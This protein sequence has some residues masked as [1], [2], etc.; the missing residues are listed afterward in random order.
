MKRMLALVLTILFTTSGLI[1]FAERINDP[2]VANDFRKTT[3]INTTLNFR[4]A[5]FKNSVNPPSGGTL[6]SITVT[7]LV[8]EASGTLR[9]GTAAVKK[10][11]E[12]KTGDLDR[13]N[14]VP[15]KDYKG[16]AIFTW[17]AQYG[18]ASSPYPSAVV[19]TVGDGTARASEPP[20][21]EPSETPSAS[22]VPTEAPTE[23]P[24]APGTPTESPTEAP[25]A[26]PEPTKTPAP[27]QKP[28]QY[29]DML[30]HW[31]AYSAGMLGAEGII[32]GEE[33][34]GRFYFYPD[35]ILTRMD[36]ITLACSVFGVKTKDSL[37]DN[38]FADMNVPD[39]MLRQAIAAYENGI[40]SGTPKNGK[41]YLNPYDTLT[42]AEAVKILD[43]G[44]KLV[45]PA[46]EALSFADSDEIPAWATDAVKNMEAYGIIRGYEDNTFRPFEHINKAQA[47][48]MLYQAFKYR[49]KV[50]KTQSVFNQIFYGEI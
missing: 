46:R 31:A 15:A 35:K 22:S 16:E 14:Y 10:N 2:L 13:L 18:T 40:I 9:L 42:R 37:A 24:S 8:N 1:V 47:G 26:S 21:E 5:D 20:A 38:P 36:F 6:V 7:Q 43:N 28:L 41:I 4:A 12:I 19:I 25:T 11:Q 27:T 17:N 30:T 32:I 45:H 48:E 39:Y 33:I 29:E 50:R 3:G 49:E 44:L 23:S 34:G